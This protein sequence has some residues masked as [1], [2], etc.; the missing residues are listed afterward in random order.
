MFIH[1]SGTLSIESH[2]EEQPYASNKEC[3]I[4]FGLISDRMKAGERDTEK[5]KGGDGAR[6]RECKKRRE[7][8]IEFISSLSFTGTRIELN[9]IL[10]Y[11]CAAHTSNDEEI[12]G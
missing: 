8:I 5:M 12:D 6:K 9:G 1:S 3:K 7:E 10:Q 4:W 2:N 11:D